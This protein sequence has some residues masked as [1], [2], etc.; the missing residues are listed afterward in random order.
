MNKSKVRKT[1]INDVAAMAGV[2]KAT[3]SR[4]I[5]NMEGVSADLAERVNGAIKE[6]DFR[7]NSLARS[8]K[9]HKTKS[10]GLI[11]PSV[12]NPVFLTVLKHVELTAMRYG[13]SLV[14]CNSAG[15]TDKEVDLIN[16]LIEKQTDG[17]VL[18]AV[19]E[20]NEGLDFLNRVRTPIVLLGKKIPGI[21]TQNATCDNEL[22]GFLAAEHLIRTGCR[23]IVF[24]FVDSESTSA[25]QDRFNGYLRA[26]QEYRLPFEEALVLRKRMDYYGVFGEVTR[27]LAERPEID[28]IF[29]ANDIAAIACINAVRGLGKSIPSDV[30]VI[31]YDNIDFCEMTRPAL[32]SV[33]NPIADMSVESVKMLLREIY[34]GGGSAEEKCF[35]PALVLRDTTRQL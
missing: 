12:D 7:P 20:Y 21:D 16:L 19:G 1:T 2:S 4:V 32:S 34:R 11:I 35:E 14:L 18:D 30:S 25:L 23:N 13:F 10:I 5:N 9:V 28:G 33:R 29:G 26:L 31:G 22:G 27:L 17:I 24:A 6:L 15:S 3:V 8:L